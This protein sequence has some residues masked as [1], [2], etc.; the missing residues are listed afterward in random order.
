MGQPVVRGFG[1]GVG[2]GNYAF[3]SPDVFGGSQNGMDEEHLGRGYGFG[4][5]SFGRGGMVSPPPGT[6]ASLRG[7]ER[8]PTSVKM[9]R[10]GP[11][12]NLHQLES[13][14]NLH[15]FQNP[16][17]SRS[18][19]PLLS[20]TTLTSPPIRNQTP[21]P[22]GSNSSSTAF[23]LTPPPPPHP[24]MICGAQTGCDQPESPSPAKTKEEHDDERELVSSSKWRSRPSSLVFAETPT[25]N[26]R[27]D[28][29]GKNQ[30]LEREQEQEREFSPPT[31]AAAASFEG[32]SFCALQRDSPGMSSAGGGTSDGYFQLR[33]GSHGSG[34]AAGS[35]LAKYTRHG[36]QD[37]GDI[38]VAQSAGVAGGIFTPGGT[39]M[40][41]L[42]PEKAAFMASLQSINEKAAAPTGMMGSSQIQGNKAMSFAKS[43]K[44][45]L[46]R[47]NL[48]EGMGLRGKASRENLAGLVGARS[49]TTKENL[50]AP[51]RGLRSMAS[52]DKLSGTDL[53]KKQSKENL[54]KSGQIKSMIGAPMPQ[55]HRRARSITDANEAQSHS[56]EKEN[57]QAGVQTAQLQQPASTKPELPESYWSYKIAQLESQ[58]PRMFNARDGDVSLPHLST[59]PK[60]VGPVQVTPWDSAPAR[61]TRRDSASMPPSP[62]R[63]AF[64]QDQF[65][66][67]K[68]ESPSAKSVASFRLPFSPSSAIVKHR[69]LASASKRTSFN[70]PTS[71]HALAALPGRRGSNDAD[72]ESSYSSEEGSGQKPVEH[73]RAGNLKRFG[74]VEAFR[75]QDLQPGKSPADRKSFRPMIENR[76]STSGSANSL[77]VKVTFGGAKGTKYPGQDSKRLSVSMTPGNRASQDSTLLVGSSSLNT[78]EG[79]GAVLSDT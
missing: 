15:Q 41:Q 75:V 73:A 24:D 56:Q 13:S 6:D 29:R 44:S 31:S 71:L 35:P 39:L 1:G 66:M 67:T 40:S 60:Q 21:S 23:K 5:G 51:G 7:N 16:D 69:P 14:R 17:G 8:L 3:G 10:S 20:P 12:W 74:S 45:K 36:S 18:I 34:M 2:G 70:T 19:T 59:P 64:A 48:G 61:L 77:A 72:S 9:V 4:G 76:P 65:A 46:S 30:D 32:E 33:K 50:P 43:L 11:T 78:L 22:N 28:S 62:I 63:T 26:S 57:H 54:L 37:L 53:K 55:Q 52:R 68:I 27:D 42:S 38:T 58:S 25:K 49:M 47:E 79:V